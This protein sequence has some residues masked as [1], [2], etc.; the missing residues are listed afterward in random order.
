M[1]C[2]CVLPVCQNTMYVCVCIILTAQHKY[3]VRSK[4]TL[5]LF[6]IH[7]SKHKIYVIKI[8][9]LIL[10]TQ[11][12]I[13]TKMALTYKFALLVLIQYTG[14]Y[15]GECMS[16]LTSWGFIWY[17]FWLWEEKND[18]NKKV[19]VCRHAGQH[20]STNNL[21]NKVFMFLFFVP[22]YSIY[23]CFFYICSAGS[24]VHN[25]INPQDFLWVI[26]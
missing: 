2:W 6:F 12:S 11:F 21:L 20:L 5:M 17:C 8:D 15:K 23:L 7:K 1:W 24:I 4:T 9:L 3:N 14:T 22:F 26:P 13:N 25:L 19:T 16:L 18:A 10:R